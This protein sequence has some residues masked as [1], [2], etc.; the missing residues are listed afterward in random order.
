[1][2]PSFPPSRYNGICPAKVKSV[3]LHSRSRLH[4]KKEKTHRRIHTINRLNNLQTL[5]LLLVGKVEVNIRHGD[6]EDDD[7]RASH[8]SPETGFV[9]RGVLLSMANSSVKENNTGRS[10]PRLQSTKEERT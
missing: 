8:A 1:M 7:Q 9:A 3:T 10:R 5:R 4:S 6:D 2:H